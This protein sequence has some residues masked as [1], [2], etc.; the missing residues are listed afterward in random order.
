MPEAWWWDL[1]AKG[2]LGDERVV[3]RRKGEEERGS[4][5]EELLM[6]LLLMTA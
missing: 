1:R 5:C 3:A 4:I 2:K 6:E